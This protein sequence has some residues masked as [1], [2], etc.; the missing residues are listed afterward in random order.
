M[1]SPDLKS[2]P[3]KALRPVMHEKAEAEATALP[4]NAYLPLPPGEA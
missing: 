4:E 1:A 2:Q 3:D